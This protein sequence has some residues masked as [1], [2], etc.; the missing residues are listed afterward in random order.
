MM[1]PTQYQEKLETIYICVEVR[2][3]EDK[4][5]WIDVKHT[6]L[7]NK[8]FTKVREN[9][10]SMLKIVEIYCK[11]LKSDLHTFKYCQASIKRVRFAFFSTQSI[12]FLSNSL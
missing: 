2:K 7:I 4:F 11:S 12:L 8:P 3:T 10:V 1:I 9:A 5:F 6:N